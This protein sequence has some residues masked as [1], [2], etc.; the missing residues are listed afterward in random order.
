MA[1]NNMFTQ[2][3]KSWIHR[4]SCTKV[5]LI[6]KDL[7]S[8]YAILILGFNVSIHI[9]FFCRN[10]ELSRWVWVKP[11]LNRSGWR[12]L[13]WLLCLYTIKW[14]IRS[15]VGFEALQNPSKEGRYHLQRKC[16]IQ[17]FEGKRNLLKDVVCL[18]W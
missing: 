2:Y 4:I 3:K 15:S 13:D 16:F 11:R 10:C 12:Y 7:Y 18:I 9:Q 14:S 17:W 5:Q 8:T 6:S 1:Q